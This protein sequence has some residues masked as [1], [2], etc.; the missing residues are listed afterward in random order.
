[1]YIFRHTLLCSAAHRTGC[2]SIYPRK[3]ANVPT[4]DNSNKQEENETTKKLFPPKKLNVSVALNSITH[5]SGHKQSTS[6]VKRGITKSLPSPQRKYKNLTGYALQS[7][8][9]E[10]TH[11]MP[12]PTLRVSS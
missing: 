5:F 11:K 7:T 10:Y 1:M 4:C 6:G 12:P 8:R 9:L 3:H 2:H